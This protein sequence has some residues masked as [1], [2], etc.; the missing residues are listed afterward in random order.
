M[1]QGHLY[2]EYVYN[3]MVNGKTWSNVGMWFK[4]AADANRW[5]NNYLSITTP[6]YTWSVNGE[7]VDSAIND[8]FQDDSLYTLVLTPLPSAI[9]QQQTLTITICISRWLHDHQYFDL[10][11]LVYTPNNADQKFESASLGFSAENLVKQAKAYTATML[12]DLIV[13]RRTDA[14]VAAD[15]EDSFKK[16][17]YTVM[18]PEMLKQNPAVIRSRFL[19]ELH[20]VI[21]NAEHDNHVLLQKILVALDIFNGPARGD[22][23]LHKDVYPEL[24][25]V[26]KGLLPVAKTAVPSLVKDS[27]GTFIMRVIW[28]ANTTIEFYRKRFMENDFNTLL[29][30]AKATKTTVSQLLGK[31]VSIEFV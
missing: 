3:Y 13:A 29:A 4:S 25:L 20:L 9:G 23:E 17:G 7:I 6:L 1:K 26:C 18:Q 31:P 15:I 24:T 16:S 30:S 5:R 22:V 8:V 14:T 10:N 21:S 19:D 2:G 11:L 27:D 28:D 12:P